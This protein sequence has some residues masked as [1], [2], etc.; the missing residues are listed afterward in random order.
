MLLVIVDSCISCLIRGKALSRQCL[1]DCSSNTVSLSECRLEQ[2][3][4]SYCLFRDD[5]INILTNS[6]MQL[7]YCVKVSLPHKLAFT[8]VDFPKL[9][10]PSQ[11]LL[12]WDVLNM[13]YVAWN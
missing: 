13:F 5:A 9:M 2:L 10:I 4:V 8:S 1:G 12:L 3:C 6:L 11:G 7:D